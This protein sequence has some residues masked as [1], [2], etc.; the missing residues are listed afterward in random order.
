MWPGTAPARFNEKQETT[1]TTEHPSGNEP[2]A[3][4][5]RAGGAG[6]TATYRTDRTN[7]SATK[8]DRNGMF[9][10]RDDPAPDVYYVVLGE[11]ARVPF[12]SLEEAATYATAVAAFS[13]TVTPVV[14]EPAT[15]C[16][17]CAWCGW[18]IGACRESDLIGYHDS[19]GCPMLR[20][21]LTVAAVTAIG[22]YVYLV[23]EE[24][25]DIEVDDE[26]MH[27]AAEAWALEMPSLQIASWLARRRF[28][29]E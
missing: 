29:R 17:W 2:A 9:W 15:S 16:V 10:R 24:G 20:Y 6:P 11:G 25:G 1:M 22:T 3:S 4:A 7:G 19:T 5:Q 26:D 18:R 23:A 8:K 13:K 27:D 12:C 14:A 28:D 21:D